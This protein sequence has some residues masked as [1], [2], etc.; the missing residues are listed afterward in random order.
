MSNEIFEREEIRRGEEAWVILVDRSA[1]MSLRFEE[2]KEFTVCVSESANE[3]TGKY[4]AWALYSFDNNFQILKDFKERYNREVQARIGSLENGG[5][6][7]LPDAIELAHRILQDDP[8]EKKYIFVIT[9]GHPTG[10]MRIQEAFSKIV[11]KTEISGIT[12]VA[13]G[14]SKKI[15]SKFRN[16]AHGKDLKQIVAKFI[17]AYRTASSDM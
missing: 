2:I 1:S 13:I 14:V 9:D 16:S 7:L 3:L 17:T 11:K 4:D 10:Y 15:S 6:S 8:R 5:L 12:L